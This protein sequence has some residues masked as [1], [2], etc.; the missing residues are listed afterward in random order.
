M[1]TRALVRSAARASLQEESFAIQTTR[2][3][4]SS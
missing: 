1:A 2:G 3:S 4:F